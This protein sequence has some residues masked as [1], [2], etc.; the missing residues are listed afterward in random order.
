MEVENL[1]RLWVDE[2]YTKAKV[3]MYKGKKNKINKTHPSAELG[4]EVA[5]H[6]FW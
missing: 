6:K 5:E 3:Y 1:F 2:K 4:S